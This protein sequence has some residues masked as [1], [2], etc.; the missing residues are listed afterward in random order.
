VAESGKKIRGSQ[1]DCPFEIERCVYST[2]LRSTYTIG[3][4]WL[5]VKGKRVRHGT[6]IKHR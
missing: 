1:N 4:S 3:N 6:P 5:E 2:R